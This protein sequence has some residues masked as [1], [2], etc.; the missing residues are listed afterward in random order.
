MKNITLT[1]LLALTIWSCGTKKT[2][3]FEENLSISRKDTTEVNVNTGTVVKT[4]EAENKVIEE[5]INFNYNEGTLTPINPEKPMTHTGPD[6]KTNTYTNASV[7]FGSGSVQSTKKSQEVKETN[8]EIKDTT[9]IK[10]NA[11]Y[12]EELDK[13]YT[14]KETD[15]K[16]VASMIEFWIGIAIAYGIIGWFIWFV[17][18][19][20][21]KQE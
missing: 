12:T 19:K 21:K 6:G 20:R 4:E 9:S 11:A 17:I 16:G 2:S 7:N 3:R 5:N 8:T 13:K 10:L 15:R 1:I 18:Y 14:I